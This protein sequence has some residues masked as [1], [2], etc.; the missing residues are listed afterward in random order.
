MNWRDA[1]DFVLSPG[2]SIR[3]A[4]ALIDRNRG[5]IALVADEAGRLL[6]TITD[7]DIRR[8]MLQ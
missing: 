8:A 6:G 7:G 5:G 1:R 4:M 3:E 2:A